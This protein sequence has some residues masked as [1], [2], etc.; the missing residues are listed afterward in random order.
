M[1]NQ[2]QKNHAHRF[3]LKLAAIIFGY[4]FWLILAQK[5]AV[6]ITKNIPLIFYLAADEYQI[7]APEKVAVTLQ[8]LRHQLQKLNFDQL[9][10]QIDAT[11]LKNLGDYT[12]QILPEQIII[13]NHVKLVSYTPVVAKVELTKKEATDNP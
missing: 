13:P 4:F 9:G 10:V 7:E 5:Q 1:I 6:T 8:G 2:T 11:K 3:I 12:I